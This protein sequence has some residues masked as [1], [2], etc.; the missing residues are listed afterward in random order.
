MEHLAGVGGTHSFK[1]AQSFANNGQSFYLRGRSMEGQIEGLAGEVID[2]T[3][4]EVQSFHRLRTSLVF[5]TV[6][7]VFLFG[8]TAWF[9]SWGELSDLLW[10]L[11]PVW[12]LFAGAIIFGSIKYSRRTVLTNRSGDQVELRRK[13]GLTVLFSLVFLV[14]FLVFSLV[15]L[16][17]PTIAL[18][19]ASGAVLSA[20]GGV[21]HLL[22]L[23]SSVSA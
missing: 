7:A 17:V 5:L 9:L 6:I 14:T 4:E 21:A 13:R 3:R 10:W 1:N 22:V 16:A 2:P 11:S 8:L 19:A 15:S 20:W 23:Q 18:M 12:L